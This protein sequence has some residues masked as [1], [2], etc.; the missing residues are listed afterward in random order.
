MGAGEDDE[1]PKP[2]AVYEGEYV[3]GV[4]SGRGKMTYPN[5]DVYDGFWAAN[6]MEGEGTYTYKVSAGG[7]GGAS[8]EEQV[9]SNMHLT[10]HR[11]GHRRHLLWLLCWREEERGG[12]LRV[13]SGL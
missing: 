3:D 13:R 6:K 4:K 1:D 12:A 8:H 2:K 10:L 5:G 11:A 9:S 7:R